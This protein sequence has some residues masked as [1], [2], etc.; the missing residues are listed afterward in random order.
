MGE[1]LKTKVW[2]QSLDFIFMCNRSQNDTISLN[3]TKAVKETSEEAKALN[4]AKATDRTVFNN[5]TSLRKPERISNVGIIHLS[6]VR[7][8]F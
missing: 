1:Y 3:E 8:R 2:K 6:A 7:K 4:E 5:E